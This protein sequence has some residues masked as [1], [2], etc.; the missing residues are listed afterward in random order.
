MKRVPELSEAYTGVRPSNIPEKSSPPQVVCHSV[1]EPRPI[2][3]HLKEEFAWLK[4]VSLTE[5]MSDDISIT[6]S[7]HHAAR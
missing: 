3:S 7:A 2:Q 6:R 5:N 4:D 1:P